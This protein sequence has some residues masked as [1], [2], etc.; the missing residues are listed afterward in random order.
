[1]DAFHDGWRRGGNVA[2][3]A[4]VVTEAESEGLVVGFEDLVKECFDVFLVLF[5]ELFL[6]SA[7]IDD[8]ADA[9]RE[10]II[11][12]EKTDLLRDAILD[13]GE[14]VL[15]ESGDDV[16][17]C[18]TD[19]QRGVNEVGFDFDD[20]NALR[21]DKDRWQKQGGDQKKESSHDRGT[22]TSKI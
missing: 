7:F 2:D 1:M 21:G 6:A 18:V 3:E 4:E 15:C 22:C 17:V 12:G 5:N 10:L 8:E 11:V 16:A 13:D 19:A 20:G 14:V 9:Q